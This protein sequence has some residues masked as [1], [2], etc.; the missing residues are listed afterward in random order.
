[1]R[2]TQVSAFME[3]RPGR[4][5]HVFNLLSEAN[6]NLVAHNIVDAADFGIL[7][8]LV[9]Q[10]AL[11]MQVLRDAGLTCRST[12]VLEV[13]VP[14]EAGAFVHRVLRPLA[15]ANVNIEYSYAYSSQCEGEARSVIKVDDLER[16]EQVLKGLIDG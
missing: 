16:A 11:A 1:M 9:D 2:I 4:M 13:T 8:M 5:L 15:E 3:N 10:P 7:H 6:I 14:D 12:L